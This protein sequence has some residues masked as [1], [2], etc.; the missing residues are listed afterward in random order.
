MEGDRDGEDS[1]RRSSRLRQPALDLPIRKKSSTVSSEKKKGRKKENKENTRGS[2]PVGRVTLA[3]R[4]L[5]IGAPETLVGREKEIKVMEDFLQSAWDG[6]RGKKRSLYVSGA[7]GTGKT[8]SLMTLLDRARSEQGITVIFLNC[9]ALGS[10][11]SPAEIYSRVASALGHKEDANDT[12]KKF[13]EAKIC[14]GS[15]KLLLV[16]DELDQLVDS[17]GHQEVL[18]SIF[19][20]TQLRN[21]NLALIGIANSLDLTDRILPRLKVIIIHVDDRLLLSSRTKGCRLLQVTPTSA[22]ASLEFVLTASFSAT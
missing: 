13:V 11:S 12:P 18:Y 15:K 17:R 2:S 6:G 19:E 8:A 10:S 5:S 21:S 3:K 16:L 22:G 14:K 1:P 20:W 7:P 9:M 4:S